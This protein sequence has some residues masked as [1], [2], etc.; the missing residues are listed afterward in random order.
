MSVCV[1]IIT[2][3]TQFEHIFLPL[4]SQLLGNKISP[5][6]PRKPDL[7]IALRSKFGHNDSQTPR[8]PKIPTL[9]TNDMK[10]V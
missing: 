5:I 1:C 10:S 6:S 4:N 3:Q 8:N 9:G 7:Q 2:C